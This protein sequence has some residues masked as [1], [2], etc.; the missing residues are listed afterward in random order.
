[1]MTTCPLCGYDFDK[2]GMVCHTSCP[3]SKH[4]SIVCCPN[5]GYQMPDE[6]Q[7]GLVRMLRRLWTLFD[8]PKQPV[9]NSGGKQPLTAL[10]VGERAEVTDVTSGAANRLAYLSALGLVPGCEVTVHQRS[11]AY[12]VQVDETELALDAQIAREIWVRTQN[13]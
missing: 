9:R 4:C 11:L 3:L 6:E 8:S 2:T 5:C 1:M 7:A 13:Q 10:Q 12:V